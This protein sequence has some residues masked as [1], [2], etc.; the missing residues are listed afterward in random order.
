M[1]NNQINI[2]NII[3][4]SLKIEKHYDFNFILIYFVSFI[5]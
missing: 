4:I 1:I 5:K 3:F 2:V